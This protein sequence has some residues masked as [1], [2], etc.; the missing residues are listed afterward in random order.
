MSAVSSPSPA[1]LRPAAA[2][3]L[4]FFLVFSGRAAAA[5]LFWDLDDL[6]AGP[7][8]TAP[9]GIWDAT[10]ANWSSSPYGL[11]GTNAP[12]SNGNDAVFAA[13][14][15]A[16]GSYQ[17]TIAPGYTPSV[18]GF[19]FQGGHVAI[20]A[21]TDVFA[22]PPPSGSA[23]ETITLS[24]TPVI[25]VQNMDAVI[26]ARLNGNGGL[27]KNGVGKITLDYGRVGGTFFNFGDSQTL[28]INGGTVELAG[29]VSGDALRIGTISINPN[30]TFRYSAT[31]SI[32][33]N[34]LF[35]VQAGGTLFVNN[36]SD[37]MGTVRGSGL[38]VLSGSSNLK[39]GHSTNQVFDGHITGT[40]SIS[41][42]G[43]S[44]TL[45]LAG[46]NSFTGSLQTGGTGTDNPATQAAT[47]GL[48]LG[49]QRAAQLATLTI[50]A[51]NATGTSLRFADLA[52]KMFVAGGLSGASEQVMINSLLL[53]DVGGNAITL[54]VGNNNTSTTFSGVLTGTGGLT[55]IGAGTLT[56]TG[57]YNTS[58]QVSTAHSYTGDTTVKAATANGISAGSAYSNSTLKL[59]FANAAVAPVSNIISDQS[60]L[61]MSGGHLQ[62]QGRASVANSQTFNG[63]ALTPSASR[64]SVTAGSGG[65]AVLNLGAFAERSNSRGALVLF[66][67]PSGSQ[68]ATHGITTTSGSVN[69]ILGAWATV[70][71]DW[72][73]TQSNGINNNIVA[74]SGYNILSGSSMMLSGVAA[75]NDKADATSIAATLT[76]GS[77]TSGSNILTV[78]D[79][80]GLIVG[81]YIS[82]S[83]LP[84]LAKITEIVSGTQF[85]I[86]V[87]ASST[88]SNQTFYSTKVISAGTG[89][90]TDINTLQIAT[91][92]RM[93]DIA[94]GTTL[95]LGESGGI[96]QINATSGV[97]SIGSAAN[98][99]SLT[100]GGADN[101]A[102][103]MVLTGN[104]Q[105]YSSI[106][107]NG[108]GAVT[109]V[110][111][112]TGELVLHGNNSYTGGTVI[113]LGRLTNRTTTALGTGVVTILP[114]GQLYMNAN[115]TNDFVI[116]GTGSGETVVPGAIRMN[117]S[118]ISGTITL[119][120]D[121][122][123]GSHTGNGLG[124]NIITGRITGDYQ[125]GISAGN[126]GG[127]RFSLRNA[128]NDFTGGLHI[129]GLNGIATALSSQNVTLRV[130]GAEVIPHGAGKGNV[131]L[132]GG[133][134]AGNFA[135]LDLFGNTETING[136]ASAG[137]AANTRVTNESTTADATLVL[138]DNNATTS[139]GGIIVDGASRKI[140]LTKIGAG[141]QTLAGA[142]TYSGDTRIS[143]GTL[144]AGAA[145][146]FSA[147]SQVI[148]DDQAGV[149]LDLADFSQTIRSLSGAGMVNLGTAALT[150][151][152]G[153]VLT[154]GSAED[155][156][157]SGDI[158]GA[159]GLNKQGSGTFIL[160]GE[161]TYLGGTTVAAGNLQI[162]LAG[163]GQS[164]SGT[165]QV[166][167]GAVLS[168]SGRVRGATVVEGTLRPGDLAGS[169]LGT[170]RFD[171]V[172]AQSLTLKSGGDAAN[173]RLALTLAGATG[174]EAN[175]LDGIQTAG[176]LG[177]TTGQHDH[178]DV[179][180]GLVIESGSYLQVG[181][182]GGYSPVYGD[183]F[184]LLDWGTVSGGDAAIS[185]AGFDP[186]A[187]LHLEVSAAMLAN[188]WFWNTDQF[189]SHGVVFVVPEPGRVLLIAVGLLALLARRRGRASI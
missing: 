140:G 65:Q 6:A 11:P 2:A 59:D 37:Y 115:V 169:G 132:T 70:G 113:T 142:N 21:T 33:N 168:G 26:S 47:G 106:K 1:A 86:S 130:D 54:Q 112:A 3:L 87:N 41:Y 107:D 164:G 51:S 176:L 80:S 52:D 66:A 67:L 71:N 114:G 152:E 64:I 27:V 84:G 17:V 39:V 74:Y 183:V 155:T 96:W 120:G 163:A 85:K 139:F 53:Q 29:L 125:L 149:M 46:I 136:L 141:M 117:S 56:L 186:V 72:A 55:K 99:G 145:N 154:T 182:A 61:V 101:T 127:G 28:T 188:G 133:T 143:S 122:V 57:H 69:G 12:F 24:G 79:T 150:P 138:G 110:K 104:L 88:V 78:A 23:V 180:G 35:D 10:S 119:A 62:V 100:A 38:I 36:I 174:N 91:A 95:R 90:V 167:A 160:S 32:Q 144:R 5:R 131:T 18:T 50:T 129:N 30:A 14:T 22:N 4:C 9:A 82:G 148:L 170:L 166:S 7:G 105:V 31:N 165:V 134:V 123:L 157:Y 25:N 187:D 42:R 48:V 20:R 121:A 111:G 108:T 158:V 83:G 15:G 73:T 171:D 173:P 135:T 189:L 147:Q 181:L 97:T 162:G 137:T 75:A 156:L 45:T 34:V 92:A 77:A 68:N 179:A 118:T 40:G 98:V 58:T 60:R 109:V 93:I 44:G 124:N 49:H 116:S 89:P 185:A 19:D 63:I 126:A 43:G 146:A 159:G 172:T 81:D 128:A 151:A 76:A 178:L 175:P 161:N 102:G 184:N 16:T 8:G 94:A 177:G 13:G 153:A 103:E